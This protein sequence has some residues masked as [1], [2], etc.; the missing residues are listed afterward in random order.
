MK[1]TL[2]VF[3][4]V[5]AILAT[6]LVGCA[7]PSASPPP[8]GTSSPT[9]APPLTTTGSTT[10]PSTSPSAQ[11]GS[12]EVRVTDAP[13]SQ[14][15][16]S[17]M[18]TVASVEIHKAGTETASPTLTATTTPTATA[19]TTPTSTATA[20][21]T[22]DESGW[23]PMK[24]SGANTFDLLKIKGLE[25]VLATG[26]LA[27]GTYTQI[28]MGV[29]KIEVTLNGGT[30]QEVKLPSG[31]LKFVQPFDV[32][33]GKTTVL[34]FDFDAMKSV[35]VTGNGQIMFKPVIKLMVTKTPGAM[36]ITSPS[37]PNGEVGV[38]YNT[39]LTAIGGKMPYTWGLASGTLTPGL[40]LNATSGV[41]S[42]TPTAAGDSTFSVKVEDSSPVKKSSTKS[43]S[44]NVA[45]TGVLQITT[46]SLPDGTKN[47]A[48]NAPVQAIGGT[49]AYTWTISAGSLP[50]GLTLDPATGSISGTPTANGDFTVTAKT[51]DSASTPNSDTQSLTIHVADEVST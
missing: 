29:T 28:R 37:L 4:A 38:A 48:Y 23:L 49:G 8:G 39:T 5:F 33:A 45:A 2:Y 21:P 50:S 15:V 12:I 27:G 35:N 6:A 41:I 13:P 9:G 47:E 18:V 31:K 32:A 44:V 14:D 1:R 42:G 30:P 34:L 10:P 3:V 26:D 7:A 20:T 11:V 43:F 24:L 36:E 17:V 25:E 16:T 19:S 40:N 46:T 22:G 51:I